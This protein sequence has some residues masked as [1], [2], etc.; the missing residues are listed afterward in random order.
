MLTTQN[1]PTRQRRGDLENSINGRCDS[2]A[3]SLPEQEKTSDAVREERIDHLRLE[4][5]AAR[6]PSERRRVFALLRTEIGRRSPAQ[7][8][9]MEFAR[10]LRQ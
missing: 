2:T 10:G 7:V 6:S 8:L 9:R 1:A 5:L 3:G 4:L